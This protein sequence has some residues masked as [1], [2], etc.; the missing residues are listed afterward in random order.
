[1]ARGE[2]AAA[3]AVKINRTDRITVIFND[4]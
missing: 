2:R 3:L 1:M 4:V